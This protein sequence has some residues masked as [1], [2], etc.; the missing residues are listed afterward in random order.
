MKTETKNIKIIVLNNGTRLVGD[1]IPYALE[2][3]DKKT[4]TAVVLRR[5]L[6]LVFNATRTTFG[7]VEYIPMTLLQPTETD[8]LL[9]LSEI[10][11]IF[12]PSLFM[13]QLYERFITEFSNLAEDDIQSMDD[14]SV[15]KTTDDKMEVNPKPRKKKTSLKNGDYIGDVEKLTHDLLNEPHRIV[16]AD[17]TVKKWK[18]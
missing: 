1:T 5:P 13:I 4:I 9:R 10:Q 2:S 16:P 11:G 18:N 7:L 6:E 17:P 8:V 12:M 3:D 15:T 14:V